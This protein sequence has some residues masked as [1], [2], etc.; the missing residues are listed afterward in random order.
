M[1]NIVIGRRSLA[2]IVVL[3]LLSLVLPLTGTGLAIHTLPTMEVEPEISAWNQFDNVT[4][5]ATL[6]APTSTELR[7]HW[8]NENGANDPDSGTTRESPDR[9]CIINI[10]TV[11]CSISYRATRT[12]DDPWRAWIDQDYQVTGGQLASQTDDSDP[13]ERQNEQTNP[14]SQPQNANP[15]AHKCPGLAAQEPDCTDVVLAQI[16]ALEVVPDVQTLDAGTTVRLTARLFAPVQQAEGVNIDFENENGSNDPDRGTTRSTPDMTCDIAQ[17]QTECFIEYQGLGGSDNWRAWI[18]SDRIQSTDNSDMTE[19]RY[20][21][22]S[23]CQQ[24]E[25][26]GTDCTTRGV[27]I[28]GPSPGEGCNRSSTAPPDEREPDCTDVVNVAFRSGGVASIDCDDNSGAQN[29][30]TERETNPQRPSDTRTGD[31]STERYQ[32]RAFD[33]FGAGL[34]DIVIKGENESGPND[35]DRS[36]TYESPDYQCT[37]TFNEDDRTIIFAERGFCYIEVRQD[38][39]EL[40]TAEICFWT[41]SAAEGQAL[42]ADEPTGEAQRADGTDPPN[43]L[44]DQVEKTW[45]NPATFRLDC[46][47]ETDRNPAGTRHDIRCTVTSSSG[48]PVGGISVD[49]EAT[50]ANDPDQTNTAAT[51]DFTCSTG[52]DGSCTFSHTGSSQGTTTYRAWIDADNNNT[53]TE[54]DTSEARDEQITPGSRAEPDNTDVVEKVWTAPPSAASITPQSDV[55]RVGECNPYTVTLTDSTG[56]GVQGAIVDVE[57][58]HER[59]DNNTQND[60]PTVSFC[61]PPASGGPNPSNVDESR[62]DLRPPDENPD[63]NGTAGGETTNATDQNGKVTFGIRVSPGNGSNGT[64]RVAITAWWET[65]DNDDPG[66][67][68][69]KATASKTWEPGSGTPGVPAGLTLSPPSSSNEPGE[70]VTYTATVSDGNGDPVEGATVTWAEDGQGDFTSQE[71]TTDSNG[72]ATATV[73]SDQEGDQTITAT[74][75]ECAEGETCSDSSTQQWARQ[76]RQTCPGFENDRRN[77]VVGTPGDDTL[78]G[79]DG[80]DIICGLDGKDTLIGRGGDDL[81]IGGGSND[82]LRGNVGDD[83]LRGNVGEDTLA[84]GA[85]NDEVYAGGGDDILRGGGGRDLLKGGGGKDVLRGRW[86]DDRLLGNGGN[87]NLNGGPGNDLL[88]GG[89]GNDVCRSGGGRDR[90]R[91]CES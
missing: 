67:S 47:P 16:G 8:E 22:Q 41:G 53:T 61:E 76:T 52:S 2:T 58:R 38:R 54:A 27:G 81:L 77:Q 29:Q 23:D 87:D 86:Q 17:G 59:A 79:S 68:E 33:Q 65:D 88:K 37:T 45:E 70:Q 39:L 11:S 12:G 75:S 26:Q 85:G 24:P 62:G 18:D 51:P 7:I 64:G 83:T 46:E 6:S 19:G 74:A 10:G 21:G 4:L 89:R 30:D 84:G 5:T 49:A 31:P 57:Q 55:A 32:C 91:S 1:N 60:E 90:F 69:P 15:N 71:S 40:G 44:A 13:S 73:T 50:G 34:N 36:T 28:A 63:N 66:S 56:A 78:R 3:T 82:I 25:D 42:C 48:S 20:S 43:D 14:G 72:Q 80:D 9:N 35:P